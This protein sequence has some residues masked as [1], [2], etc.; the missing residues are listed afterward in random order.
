M[1]PVGGR[2][3]AFCLGVF[4]IVFLLNQADRQVLSVLIPGGLR[5][6]DTAAPYDH[7]CISFSDSQQGLLTGPAFTVVFTLSG[8]PL[9][10]IADRHSRTWVLCWG[11]VA[12][13]L[14]MV[15]VFWVQRFWQLLL[16]Q[17]MLGVGEA[18]CNPPVYSLLAD[19][20]SPASRATAFSVYNCG[21][22]LGWSVFIAVN[23]V[24]FIKFRY[25]K[26]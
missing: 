20:Y 15:A 26:V 14:V 17:M 13:S 2:Y 18:T 25:Y 19:L 22:Y 9:S 16:L 1:T 24:N 21:V 7:D 12:W 8:I 4:L 10:W 23:G 3:A 5:C 11:L 6:N